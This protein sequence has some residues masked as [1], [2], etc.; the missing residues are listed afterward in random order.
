MRKQAESCPTMLLKIDTGAD[1]NLLNSTTFDWVI[2]KMSIL[3]PLTLKMENYSSSRIVVLGKF[4]A[5]VRW[6][7]KIYRQPFFVTT[8][9]TSPNLLSRDALGVVKPCYAVEAVER[10]NLQADLQDMPDLQA[11]LQEQH[12]TDLRSNLQGNRPQIYSIEQIHCCQTRNWNT[13]HQ[14]SNRGQIQIRIWDR[15]LLGI[16]KNRHNYR[17]SGHWDYQM[18]NTDRDPGILQHKTQRSWTARQRLHL[19]SIPDPNLQANLQ[20]ILDLWCDLQ[21][22]LQDLQ[23]QQWG[24]SLKWPI[25]WQIQWTLSLML[26]S[27]LGFKLT[28]QK[29]WRW[30]RWDHHNYRCRIEAPTNIDRWRIQYCKQIFSQIYRW[31]YK[32]LC[33]WIYKSRWIYSQIYKDLK[34]PK[35][36]LWCHFHYRLRLQLKKD[37]HRWEDPAS[38]A[39]SMWVVSYLGS[40]R[41]HNLLGSTRINP[42]QIYKAHQLT[43]HT[44]QQH[45]AIPNGN[46]VTLWN[47]W[48]ILQAVS[49]NKWHCFMA[50][51]CIIV[52][53]GEG[54]SCSYQCAKIVKYVVVISFQTINCMEIKNHGWSVFKRIFVWCSVVKLINQTQLIEWTTWIYQ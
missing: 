8:A 43:G 25:Q 13:D 47:V 36:L 31:I 4:F 54:L 16:L 32:K 10:S 2:G 1:V 26:I 33:R 52:Y 12:V 51:M 35:S 15:D 21:L 38:K 27:D 40:T 19:I 41:I 18:K 29:L 6:K 7:G 24:N 17:H 3:Q 23:H 5:F 22:D 53:P 11:N 48:L 39:P 14:T 49:I 28:E 9:N 20:E 37:L 30:N 45:P 42:K 46:L 44:P 34:V 50:T